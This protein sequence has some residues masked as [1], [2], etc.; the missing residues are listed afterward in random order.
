ME[1][2]DS[3]LEGVPAPLVLDA[4][5]LHDLIIV[6]QRTFFNHSV[7]P[8]SGSSLS[9]LLNR[10]VTPILAV[11][12]KEAESPLFRALV[13]YDGSMNAARTLRDFIGFA[14][15]F[16]FDITI[17]IADPDEQKVEWILEE[18]SNYLRAHAVEN[19][20]V[21]VRFSSSTYFY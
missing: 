14:A 15:P 19:Y 9:E 6:G 8:N 10:T 1:H 2:L 21:P 11:P 13:A 20:C 7:S 18:A 17:M 16:D 3:T 4:A 5:K 12:R